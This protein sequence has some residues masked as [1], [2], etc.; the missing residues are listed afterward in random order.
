MWL[1]AH[2]S[3]QPLRICFQTDN[4]R[5]Q[6]FLRVLG[7]SQ[8]AV[9]FQSWGD[10]RRKRPSRGLQEPFFLPASSDP[11]LLERWQG[12]PASRNI[13]KLCAG[14]TQQGD[15]LRGGNAGQ[16]LPLGE[17]A[18]RT[19]WLLKRRRSLSCVTTSD[20]WTKADL[21]GGAAEPARSFYRSRAILCHFFFFFNLPRATFPPRLLNAISYDCRLNKVLH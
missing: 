18:A 2:I 13:K 4:C 7:C 6:Q 15:A 14:S 1:L 11:E 8:S 21:V 16:A 9:R 10:G 12:H 17:S 3:T 19:G 5:S 20:H